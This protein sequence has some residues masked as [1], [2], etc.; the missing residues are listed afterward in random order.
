MRCAPALLLGLAVAPIGVACSC[1]PSLSPHA[2]PALPHVSRGDEGVFIGTVV[3]SLPKSWKHLF[4]LA[5]RVNGTKFS[6][7][8]DAGDA[9]PEL[10]PAQQREWTEGMK[11]VTIFMWG[12]ILTPAQRVQIQRA[13]SIDDI[14]GPAQG[15]S[16]PGRRVRLR[17][18]ER[19]TG[20]EVPEFELFTGMGGG[21]CGVEF[22]EGEEYIV[23]AWRDKA[24]R[25]VTGICAP[26][27]RVVENPEYVKAL[28]A[29]KKGVT[30]PPHVYGWIS[31]IA[32]SEGNPTDIKR[33]TDVPVNLDGNCGQFS[34]V[35]DADGRFVFE[36]LNRCT[37]RLTPRLAGWSPVGAIWPIDLTKAPCA[38]VHVLLEPLGGK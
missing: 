5:E 31:G 7:K 2:C 28:R 19:F 33:L 34:A 10:T 14:E 35:T 17:V 22:Q 11:R 4:E 25:W 38:E 13:T 23:S 32:G 9:D 1:A 29:W 15:V 18:L 27:F 36:D 12:D 16:W 21:D 26:T 30:L 37:Y 8:I 20:P 24:G 6:F 3:E